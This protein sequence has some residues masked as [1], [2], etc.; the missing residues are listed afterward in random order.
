M[1][2]STARLQAIEAVMHYAPSAPPLSFRET[3]AED[4]FGTNV[5]S[6]AVMQTRL[7]KLIYQSLER[8]IDHGRQLDA[9]I[10][11]AVASAMKDWAIEKGATHFAHVFYPL[12]GSTAEKHDSFL[13]PDGYGSAIAE[14]AGK[15]LLQGEPDASSLP[16][17]GI[18]ST[19]EARG[20]TAWDVTS[21][22]YL[23]ENRTYHP[24][25]PDRVRLLDG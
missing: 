12:T 2:G 13:E 10:A 11:D 3:P 7:P 9:S 14:F 18:R 5:F 22:A 17:G 24:L 16:S 15:T 23:L 21:P 1:S 19:F 8:T 6:K 4:L 20:Y 25:H